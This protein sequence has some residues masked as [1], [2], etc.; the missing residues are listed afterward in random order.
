M[1]TKTKSEKLT[2][3]DVK[4]IDS[5]VLI[6][7]NDRETVSPGGIVIP[8]QAADAPNQ[9]VVVAKG[10]GRWGAHGERLAMQVEVGDTVLFSPY[11]DSVK[12]GNE[13]FLIVEE[14]SLYAVIK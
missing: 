13:T 1:A 5:R 8:D 11:A 9:G 7:P 2:A 4:M 10:P 12:L 3:I 6:R 14:S